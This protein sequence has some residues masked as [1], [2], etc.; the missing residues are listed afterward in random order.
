MP[1]IAFC[2]LLLALAAGAG[3]ARS[4]GES[5]PA[6]APVKGCSWQHLSD[7]KVGLAAWVQ[8]C[9]F[10]ARKI[11]FSLRGAG[12]VLHYSDGGDEETLVEVHALEAGESLEAGMR[13]LWA[14]GAIFAMP[15]DR[16]R[17][18]FFMPCKRIASNSQ[19]PVRTPVLAVNC[20]ARGF[21]IKGKIVHWGNQL[22]FA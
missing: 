4:G 12:L 14:A 16:L 21:N 18:T 5:P 20:K 3:F 1:K 11:T 19:R 7:A 17:Y 8:Q 13:R 9:E 2:S 10:D 22:N 6:R 15:N